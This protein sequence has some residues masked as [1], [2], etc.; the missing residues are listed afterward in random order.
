MNSINRLITKAAPILMVFLILILAGSA[1]GPSPTPPAPSPTPK[2]SPSPGGNLPPVVSSLTAAQMQVYPSGTVEI[3][4][5]AS[6]PN[7]DKLNFTWAA[8]GGSFNGAG[9]T[10]TWQAP[11]QYGTYT[12]TV[13]ADDGKGASAQ[14]SLT[15]SVGANQPP[16]ISSL[17]PNPAVISPG[18]SS[19]ITC[20]ANDP[21]GDVVRYNW[22]ASEGSITGVGNKVSWFPPNKGGSFNIIVI[23]SD[24]KGGETKGNVVV[25]VATATKTVTINPVQ[26]E[27][28]TVSK[29]DKDRS[30]TRAGDDDKN[31]GYR[32]FWSFNI[33]SLNNTDVKDARLIFTTRTIS[34]S[35]FDFTGP[36][37]LGGLFI[38]QVRYSDQLPD[39]GITGSKLEKTVPVI[40]EQPTVL[41]VTPEIV[42]LVQGSATRFQIEAG[43]WKEFNGNNIAEWIE[44][45]GAKLEVTYTEK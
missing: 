15:L 4:C 20:V 7:G 19:T 21:D 35:P 8:T 14:S 1:C 40:Y 31:N 10:V 42:Q 43:F 12:I 33:W 37:S 18:G 16:Q 24:G 5:V 36:N 22:S 39:F 45:T 44:W 3:Q 11:K 30:K 9:Q 29:T 38:W 28:G 25:T 13:T 6:D 17:A 32:A 34:G 2:P 41:D 23:V 27:T 26:E